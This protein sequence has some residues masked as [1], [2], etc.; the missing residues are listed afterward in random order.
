MG[1]PLNKKYMGN[2]NLGATGTDTSADAGI[3]G[4]GVASVTLGGTNNS[5]GFTNG[6]TSQATFSAPTLANGVTATGT[7]VTYAAGALTNATTYGTY[8]GTGVTAVGTFTA[9]AQKSTN[10]SGTGATFNVAKTSGTA[11]SST[12]TVTLASAGSGYVSGNTITLDGANLG[13]VTTTND[14]TFTIGTFVATSGTIASITITNKGSGYAAA[15]TLTLTVGT[16]GTLTVTPVLTIDTGAVGSSTYRENAIIAYAYINGALREVDLV[17]QISSK[18]YKV[19]YSGTNYTARIRYDAVADGTAGYTTAE[20]YELNIVALDSA[21]GSY[22]VRKLYNRTCTLNPVAI[23]RLSASAGSAITAGV[24]TK[25]SF[26]SATTS[27]VQIEN[28]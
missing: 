20:G 27:V 15:P 17:K 11:Y 6:S 18:R 3:G 14:L 13:G 2:R 9:V 22:L 21:G 5:I 8:T 4:E 28:A 19:N 1:R 24:Q 12:I 23:S 25:W 16:K 10:G 7:V 26:A